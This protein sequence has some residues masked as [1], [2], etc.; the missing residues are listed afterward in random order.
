MK[1]RY[2]KGKITTCAFADS[3]KNYLGWL[4]VEDGY[5]VF[6]NNTGVRKYLVQYYNSFYWYPKD[7]FD[8]FYR[9]KEFFV[10]DEGR[11][12]KTK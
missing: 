4:E 11:D 8:K 10:D 6:T 9:D 12:I 2:Q 1:V 3:I 5:I 7:E